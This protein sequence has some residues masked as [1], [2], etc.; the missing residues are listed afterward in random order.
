MH[1]LLWYLKGVFGSLLHDWEVIL[2]PRKYLRL[3]IYHGLLLLLASPAALNAL[4]GW[5][6]TRLMM[7]LSR[8]LVRRVNLNGGV[9]WSPSRLNKA[10][11]L[12]RRGAHLMIWSHEIYIWCVAYHLGRWLLHKRCSLSS[13]TMCEKSLRSLLEYVCGLRPIWRLYVEMVG[14][15]TSLGSPNTCSW[16]GS[17]NY[18]I[19]L[20]RWWR[21]SHKLSRCWCFYHLGSIRRDASL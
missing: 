7:I 1:S 2:L 6:L 18:C 15:V 13:E 19:A 8:C 9:G 3:P 17:G 16:L 12:T 21:K 10:V 5:H 20:R 11:L 4:A 14:H